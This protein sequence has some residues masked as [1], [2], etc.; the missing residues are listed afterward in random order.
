[1]A[2]NVNTETLFPIVAINDYWRGKPLHLNTWRRLYAKGILIPGSDE[3]VRLE[4]VH[5]AGTLYCSIEAL[6]R[7]VAAQNANS[8]DQSPPESV[9]R[10]QK[11]ATAELAA[12]L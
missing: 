5:M 1:M 4:V 10:R 2:I 11:A 6:E 3:R 7:F 12:M 8:A 9:R